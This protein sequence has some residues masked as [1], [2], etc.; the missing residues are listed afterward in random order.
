VCFF[1]FAELRRFW[2]PHG[3]RLKKGG[4]AAQLAKIVEIDFPIHIDRFTW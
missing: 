4:C 1:V 2:E 3:V